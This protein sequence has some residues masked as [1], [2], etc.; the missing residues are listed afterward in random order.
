MANLCLS[1]S[2]RV[3]KNIEIRVIR[4]IRVQKHTHPHGKIRV[5][6]RYLWEIT[7]FRVR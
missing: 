6:P 4:D 2:I 3:Q 1:V 5:H 7:L